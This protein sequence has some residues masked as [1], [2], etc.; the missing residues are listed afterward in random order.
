MI[1]DPIPKILDLIQSLLTMNWMA[2]ES[3]DCLAFVRQLLMKVVE[4][5]EQF[6]VVAEAAVAAVVIVAADD[7]AL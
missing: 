5:V 6:V 7:E 2:K 4:L 3:K 1:H